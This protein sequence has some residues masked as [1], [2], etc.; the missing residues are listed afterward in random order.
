MT[1][2]PVTSKLMELENHLGD[3]TPEQQG[4]LLSWIKKSKQQA[5]KLLERVKGVQDSLDTL[6]VLI[7]YQCF[8]LEATRRE[9]AELRE[10]IAQLQQI[11]ENKGY[12]AE[13]NEV[14]EI[15]EEGN[16]EV[17]G[18]CHGDLPPAEGGLIDL[19]E[20][21]DYIHNNECDHPYDADCQCCHC[22]EYR[23]RIRQQSEGSD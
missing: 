3:L 17:I 18:E 23:W 16:V 7:Q 8:D 15:D 5:N 4:R 10:Q 19:P 20:I 9:N 14:I 11:L 21:G 2:D 13:E 22:E 12:Y 1:F 6:R